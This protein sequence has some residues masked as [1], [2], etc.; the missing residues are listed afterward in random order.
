VQFGRTCPYE[1]SPGLLLAKEHGVPLTNLP[2][3]I[4]LG[5][6]DR[7]LAHLSELTGRPVPPQLLLERGWLLDAMADAHKYNAAGRPVIYGE[8]ELVYA[9]TS[10]CAE[11]GAF[12]A[13]I[14]TGTKADK[15][16][17]L[18]EPLLS[19]AEEAPVVLGTADFATI[20]EA[21]VRTGA[22]IA[23]GHSG[24]RFLTERRGI[25]VMRVGYPIT[26]RIG[27]QRILT[28]GYTGTMAFLDRFTNTLLEAKYSTYRKKRKDDLFNQGEI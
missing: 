12:P 11:N 26:D 22:N 2:L 15:L 18:V 13:V 20:E 6:T 5:N 23:I 25:P 24:G 14:A 8:P 1:I 28:A 4:G 9:L 17:P 16:A 19:D 21:A 10:L 7:F 27:G 3:P